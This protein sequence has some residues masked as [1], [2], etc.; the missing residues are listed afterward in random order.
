MSR[1][2]S[3][4]FTL[5]ELLAVIAIAAILLTIAI[6]SFQESMRA[7]RVATTGNELLAS[8]SLARSEGIRSTRGGGVCTSTNGTSCGGNWNNGW[9]V[10]TDSN[11]NGA[12]NTGET[13]VRYSQAKARLALTSAV[14]TIAFDSR[15][16][17]IGGAQQIQLSPEGATAPIRCLRI[18]VTGQTRVTQGACS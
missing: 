17:I 9:L 15:G 3:T 10:W 1:R 2:H 18:A 14:T 6:P 11:G 12:L 16:R 7:N 8:L 13:V 5:V 4:G